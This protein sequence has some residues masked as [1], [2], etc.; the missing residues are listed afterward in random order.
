MKE[1]V[2]TCGALKVRV[3]RAFL[4]NQLFIPQSV[5]GAKQTVCNTF[6][7]TNTTKVRNVVLSESF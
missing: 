4:I 5:V 7:F 1:D 6:F 3:A 2:V